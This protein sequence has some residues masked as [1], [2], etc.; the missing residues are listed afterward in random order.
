MIDVYDIWVRHGTLSHRA[1]L[2]LKFS[3]TSPIHVGS[4]AKGEVLQYALMLK[5][6]EILIPASTWKG[7]FRK[8]SEVLAKSITEKPATFN[9]YEV[10]VIK[11]HEEKEKISHENIVDVIE[12]CLGNITKRYGVDVLK[13]FLL[14]TIFTDERE[15]LDA[16]TIKSDAKEVFIRRKVRSVLDKLDFIAQLLCP[17]CRLYGAPNLKGKITFLDTIIPP[18]EYSSRFRTYVGI[19]RKS[20]T[21][22]ERFLYSLQLVTPK[23]IKLRIIVNNV[24]KG[25]AEATLWAAT[26]DYILKEGLSLGARK[27]VGLGI[28]KVREGDSK[29][30]VNEFKNLS[31]E[32]LLKAL[33]N[34]KYNAKELKMKEYIN[35][36]KN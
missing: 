5:R 25:S 27:S 15:L 1:I 16:L 18:D 33:I 28:L 7:I 21:R 34:Y 13:K 24:N 22:S 6:G 11:V 26:L 3:V 35:Y 19:D 14:D 8:L 36:L 20:G 17:I 29:V 9:D 23:E 12:E 10:R 32:D 2:D 31:S 30:Y 4:G